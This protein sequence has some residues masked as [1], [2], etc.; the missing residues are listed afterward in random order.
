[1][2][3]ADAA[4]AAPSRRSTRH[5]ATMS[6]ASES[7]ARS[8]G[9]ALVRFWA[10]L[11]AGVVVPAVPV[12]AGYLPDPI[13]AA[14]GLL[15]ISSG[16]L[17]VTTRHQQPYLRPPPRRRPC[18]PCCCSAS[19][20]I[21]RWWCCSP[22][23]SPGSASVWT[24]APRDAGSDVVGI[25]APPNRYPDR[26]RD[27]IQAG[28]RAAPARGGVGGRHPRRAAAPHVGARGPRV[29]RTG[30]GPD[31]AGRARRCRGRRW[32]SRCCSRGWR[33]RWRPGSP[34]LGPWRRTVVG[35]QGIVYIV[36]RA[37]GMPGD[38]VVHRARRWS[39]SRPG[40]PWS[41]RWGGTTRGCR[42]GCSRCC[43]RRSPPSSA[44]SRSAGRR[45]RRRSPCSASPVLPLVAAPRSGAG[46]GGSQRDRGDRARRCAVRAAR[47]RR[48]DP[49]GPAGCA[50]LGAGR[51]G[52]GRWPGVSRSD[53]RF[54]LLL[55][56]R[57]V[58]TAPAGSCWPSGRAGDRA[59]TP[60]RW[61]ALAALGRVGLPPPVAPGP[62][63]RAWR[64]RRACCRPR[65][66]RHPDD[67]DLVRWLA[68]AAWRRP[69][70]GLMRRREVTPR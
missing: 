15:L 31:G 24:G 28:D 41:A 36:V 58:R 29:R 22:S 37:A 61:P 52:A 51:A 18:P 6:S 56:R 60:C 54:L 43:S 21:R 59:R 65:P 19:A 48:L 69:S 38:P 30:G 70:A 27:R 68:L 9:L 44:A 45:A 23:R 39:S 3:P 40:R 4:V 10:A 2:P 63:R 62:R 64:R 33:S 12:F 8:S 46:A 66:R 13:V 11:A 49:P 34:S 17:I 16:L 55:R 67:G 25:V 5:N 50:G 7:A 35:T 20:S 53:R 42:A 14:A 32:R 1:M 47:H 57:L 26:H